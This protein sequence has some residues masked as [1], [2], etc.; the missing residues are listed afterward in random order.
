MYIV[1]YHVFLPNHASVVLYISADKIH[2][3][4]KCLYL[5]ISIIK[6]ILYTIYLANIDIIYRVPVKIK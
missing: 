2:S 4:Y 6:Y 3:M 1:N 5:L